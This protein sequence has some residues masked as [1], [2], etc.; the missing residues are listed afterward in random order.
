MITT[1]QIRAA[2]AILRITVVE[3]SEKSGV[4]V[5]T[6]KRLEA[7]RGV[8]AV[9]TRTLEEIQ[10]ALNMMGVEFLGTPEDRPG[11]RLITL[12]K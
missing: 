2:R 12:K 3:L 5:A 1:E 7:G 11:V 8:P 4:G 6:I 9:H 10:K